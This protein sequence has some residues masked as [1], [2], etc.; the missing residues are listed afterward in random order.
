MNDH[1]LA[2]HIDLIKG[3]VIHHAGNDSS[4]EEESGEAH[5]WQTGQIEMHEVGF[6]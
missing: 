3:R 4:D 6:Q 2:E 1:H 5:G